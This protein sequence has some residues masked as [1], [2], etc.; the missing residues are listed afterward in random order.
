M[1]NKN[2][3][4]LHL[5]ESRQTRAR[6]LGFV[7]YA[8]NFAIEQAA[9]RLLDIKKK[10]KISAIVGGKAKYWSEKLQIDPTTLIP[11][12]DNLNL[13]DE[14]FDL[15]INA[16]SLHWYNDPVGNLIQVRNA[17]KPDGL[18]LAF[19]W[20]GDTLKELR[21]AFQDA[22]LKNENGIS[23]RVAPMVEL[24]SAGDLLVRAG[25]ALSVADKIDLTV[26]YNNPLELLYDL[27]RMGETNIMVERRKTF[28]KRSTLNKCLEIYSKNYPDEN[29][30]NRIKATFQLFCLTG[31][32]PSENQQK[33]L[34]R[35][36]AE[37]K[38]S[39][40]LKSYEL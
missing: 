33:P 24:K 27:R 26:T 18:M 22:E 32:A 25:F 34:K 2:I 5:L 30:R 28:L 20:G 11:D 40:V 14:S 31:W 7:E 9:E 39:E 10:F 19:L 38:F 6:K 1:T 17:L 13:Q 35:G 8:D 37:K 4:E 12:G 36:S 15:V 16:L 3:F 29:E 21:L 23:P